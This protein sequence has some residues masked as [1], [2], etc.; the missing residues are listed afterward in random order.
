MRVIS[1]FIKSSKKI[2]KVA[3]E[4]KRH[5]DL[6]SSIADN[7]KLKKFIKWKP[8]YKN[9]NKIV[10]SCLRWENKLNKL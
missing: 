2:A 9:L 4:K 7:K 6:A 1:S 5:G 8:K 3:I 10:M